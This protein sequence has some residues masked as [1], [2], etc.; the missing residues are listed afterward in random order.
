MSVLMHGST[1][2]KTVYFCIRSDKPRIGLNRV[3][4]AVDPLFAKAFDFP[5]LDLV[6]K[7]KDVQNIVSMPSEAPRQDRWDYSAKA[8]QKVKKEILQSRARS[9]TI[10]ELERHY[11]LRDS[12]FE[13]ITE[14]R[15]EVHGT[16]IE[17]VFLH[18]EKGFTK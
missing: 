16:I 10:D 8:F 15:M 17:S 3:K 6:A 7:Q 4:A 18:E 13:T 1:E 11:T 2:S 12:R 5:R 9:A 14:L